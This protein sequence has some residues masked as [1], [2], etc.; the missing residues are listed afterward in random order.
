MIRKKISHIADNIDSSCPVCNHSKAHSKNFL[1]L[2]KYIQTLWDSET[3]YFVRCLNCSYNYAIPNIPGDTKF[4]NIV[5]PDRREYPAWKWD[6]QI[7]YDSIKEIIKQNEI[8]NLRLL[9]IGAGN[10]NFLKKVSL[11]LAGKQNLLAT[12]FSS[13]GQNEINKNGI[14]CLSTDVRNIKSLEYEKNFNFICMFQVLEHMNEIDKL[15]KHLSWLLR[16]DGNLFI[17]VPNDLHRIF[18]EKRG[19]IEDVPPVHIGRWSK[20]AFDFISKKHGFI[21]INYV[22][23]PNNLSKNI[24]KFISL[25]YSNLLIL[26][27]TQTIDHKIFRKMIYAMVYS[28]LIMKNIRSIILLSNRNL[29]VSQFIHLRKGMS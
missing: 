11:N 28:F 12:E 19:L 16:N 26:K 10:G 27:K 1:V 3:C 20:K 18:F 13:Y 29:G 24:L 7:A 15:F 8:S 21:V 23:E 22:L 17:T 25:K 6:F 4:Y 2:S 5:Y 14:K 9:E